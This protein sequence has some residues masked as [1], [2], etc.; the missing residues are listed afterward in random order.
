MPKSLAFQE[1]VA[2]K[3]Q[4]D[5]PGTAIALYRDMIEAAIDRRGRDNYRRA[6][7][8]LQTVQY[9][10]EQL[11]QQDTCQQYVQH[12]RTQHNNLPA[13]KQELSKAGF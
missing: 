7:Q 13:L 11:Q 5:Q 6:T 12:L 2:A 1:R 10:Y 9:L 3:I 8:Y 4:A